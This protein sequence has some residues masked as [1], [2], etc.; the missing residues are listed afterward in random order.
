M[1]TVADIY[2]MIDKIAPFNIRFPYDNVGVL[3]GDASAEVKRIAV[4][5]DITRD[6]VKR[7]AENECDLI[8]SNPPYIMTDEISALQKEVLYEPLTALD[9]GLDGYD[10][11][12]CLSE[13]WC[14]K[15]KNNGFIAMECGENQSEYII[16]LFKNKYIES[17]IIFDFNNI[18]RVVTFRI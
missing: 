16:E 13:R 18:D 11:Y 1:A 7:A 4:C 15:V 3:V 17:N 14:K 10:F 2:K 6:V 9:G 12:R 8:V 5:L